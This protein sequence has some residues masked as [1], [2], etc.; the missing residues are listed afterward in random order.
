MC[1]SLRKA[2]CYDK[3]PGGALFTQSPAHVSQL[4][5]ALTITY[6]YYKSNINN[7]I[8][9]YFFCTII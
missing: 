2:L 8:L 9:L 6:F 3:N 5:P 1:A 7:N 4:L